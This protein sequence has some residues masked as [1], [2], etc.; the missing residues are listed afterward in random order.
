MSPLFSHSA[1]FP[2]IAL[3]AATTVRGHGYV[4]NIV[5]DGTRYDGPAPVDQAGVLNEKTPIRQIASEEPITDVTSNLIACGSS[6]S[7]PASE[8]AKVSSGSVLKAQVR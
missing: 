8:V 1:W 4:G 6:T 2:I 7:V 3:F 5:A